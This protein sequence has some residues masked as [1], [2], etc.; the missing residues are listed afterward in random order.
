MRT[1]DY[2]A[3]RAI[4]ASRLRRRVFLAYAKE[5]AVYVGLPGLTVGGFG[6]LV[7]AIYAYV[8][9]NLAVFG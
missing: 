1:M 8:Q 9:H 7:W 5:V 2:K 6:W 3:R 4:E